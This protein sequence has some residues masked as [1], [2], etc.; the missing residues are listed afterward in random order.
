MPLEILTLIFKGLGPLYYSR[1]LLDSLI[2]FVPPNLFKKLELSYPQLLKLCSLLR[3]FPRLINMVLELRCD[4]AENG[5]DYE[6]GD[7]KVLFDFFATA[8]SLKS[9]TIGNYPRLR[10]RLLSVKFVLSRYP[11]L[12]RLDVRYDSLN[13][14]KLS[15]Q[16]RFLSLFPRLKHLA[17]SYDSTNAGV[18]D[19]P[20]FTEDE[21]TKFDL[22]DV[23]ATE[24]A[25]KR[26][27]WQTILGLVG[28]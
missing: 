27:E 26:G 17:V 22:E 14:E 5:V 25:E 12:D 11:T 15:H 24:G 7:E 4:W 1:P 20:V 23:S 13:P 6:Q 10:S 3:P 9:L 16:Y 18:T 28:D 19:D 21:R 2:S 8:T